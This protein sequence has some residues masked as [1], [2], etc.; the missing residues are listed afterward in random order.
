M[1]ASVVIRHR[2]G[3][4]LVEDFFG[5]EQV[6]GAVLDGHVLPHTVAVQVAAALA[7]E[8]VALLDK[9]L[10]GVHV[11][12]VAEAAAPQVHEALVVSLVGMPVGDVG[13]E[14]EDQ[15]IRT[16]DDGADAVLPFAV[17]LLEIR[18]GDLPVVVR[19]WAIFVTISR[20]AAMF[21]LVSS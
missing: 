6:A 9:E 16:A 15:D 18:H 19:H 20:S 13:A 8:V 17:V 4:G 3:P 21:G 14:G 1:S 11:A 10:R 7:Q 2:R 12:E 5:V